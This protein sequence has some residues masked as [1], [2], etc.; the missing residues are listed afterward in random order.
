VIGTSAY[1]DSTLL[2]R[3]L[4]QLHLGPRT[5]STLCHEVLG[6]LGAPAAICDRVAIALLGADPRVRQL[7]DGRWG[8]VPEAQGSPLL[9]DCAF[10]VVDVETTGVRAGYGDRITEIAVVVVHGERREIVFESLV[11]PE[12]PIPR[13]ICTITNI[14]NEMVRHAPRFSEVSERLLA[15]LAGRVFVAHNARFDWNF[16]SAE[17][18]RSR[19]LT[20]DGTRFCT[21]RLARRLV[22]GVRS[23]GLDNL[24]RFFGFHNEAR[25]RAGGDALVTAELLCRLLSLAREEGARTL[26]D[27][28][29][30]E[31]RRSLVRRRRRRSAMPT[32]PRADS[33]Q[34]ECM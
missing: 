4:A 12:R 27:L 28:T 34:E 16:V 10:A 21:V 30:I 15:A 26:Q 31:A 9:D 18:R 3:V 23:C 13:A 1:P 29:V 6:L 20:L 24:C 7:E 22:K 5:P 11:N 14:T 2:E 32:E 25:H 33:C 17:L 8:L 19:D